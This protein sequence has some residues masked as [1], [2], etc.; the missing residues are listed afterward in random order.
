MLEGRRGVGSRH[1]FSPERIESSRFA[2]SWLASCVPGKASG[3]VEPQQKPFQSVLLFPKYVSY[4]QFFWLN[5]QP[6]KNSC[7]HHFYIFLL[8]FI[9]VWSCLL[10][11]ASCRPSHGRKSSRLT[12][13]C[14]AP[15]G[16]ATQDLCCLARSLHPV[17]YLNEINHFRCCFWKPFHQQI[18]YHMCHMDPHGA[19][20]PQD[21][22]GETLKRAMGLEFV[23]PWVGWF[24]A[25]SQFLGPT[26]RAPHNQLIL[27]GATEL[28]KQWQL[29]TLQGEIRS[30]SSWPADQRTVVDGR[31]SC[32]VASGQ[33]N[34]RLIVIS[35]VIVI[36]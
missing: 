32:C 19:T 24:H 18:R 28:P 22:L 26:P 35:N 12:G 3:N 14:L 33:T 16:A 29:A 21:H 2:W 11:A 23:L 9:H 20:D 17:A 5:L 27:Q 30:T 25:Q 15:G 4:S 7:L 36:N 1:R 31:W 13:H 6:W 10:F 8:Y 34:R